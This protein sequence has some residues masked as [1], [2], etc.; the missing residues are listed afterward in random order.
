M[1]TSVQWRIYIDI[2]DA[3]PPNFLHFHTI[4]GNYGLAEF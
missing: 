2:F 4:F 3:P 1:L